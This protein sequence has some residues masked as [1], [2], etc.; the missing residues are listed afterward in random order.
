MVFDPSRDAV[1]D[2]S[3][4]PGLILHQRL[5]AEKCFLLAGDGRSDVMKFAFHIDLSL[6]GDPSLLGSV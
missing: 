6:I 4:E 3:Y 5:H 2:T 1:G